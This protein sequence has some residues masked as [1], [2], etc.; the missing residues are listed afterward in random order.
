MQSWAMEIKKHPFYRS[1]QW[2]EGTDTIEFTLLVL[3]L[4]YSARTRPIWSWHRA[5]SRFALSQWE[6]S[7]LCNDVSHWLGASLD[8]PWWQLCSLAHYVIRT[9]ADIKLI[10]QDR[11][12]F[13]FHEIG[14]Q[15]PVPSQC[16]E[17]REKANV[18]VFPNKER[19]KHEKS[20]VM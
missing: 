18:F 7:L 13:V 5:D 15:P 2:M 11:W 8:Q 9:S 17:M 14:F 16:P 20:Q 4:E 3:R 19:L 12:A 6:T 10:I 1:E